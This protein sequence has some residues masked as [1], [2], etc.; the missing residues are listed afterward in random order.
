[1]DFQ[2]VLTAMKRY[3]NARMQIHTQP[4]AKHRFRYRTDGI[5]Y[6]EQS[7]RHPMAIN[8]CILPQLI[9]FDEFI[10]LL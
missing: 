3:P 1:M 4:V 8:V 7:R 2:A 9:A 10:F 5:R 6:L